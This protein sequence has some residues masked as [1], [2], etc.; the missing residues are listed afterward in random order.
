MLRSPITALARTAPR[1]ARGYAKVAPIAVSRATSTGSRAAGTIKT[2]Q[3]LELKTD[4]QKEVCASLCWCPVPRG[5]GQPDLDGAG[6]DAD[7]LSNPASSAAKA[8]T[9]T[10][11]SYSAPAMPPVS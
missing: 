5:S 6:D 11:R 9:T 2:D 4:L 1:F 8:R 10:Q 7:D 3:G